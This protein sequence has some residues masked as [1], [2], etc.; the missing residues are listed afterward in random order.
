M[1]SQPGTSADQ[2][3]LNHIAMSQLFLNM[4]HPQHMMFRDQDCKNACELWY[5]VC[6]HY[7]SQESATLQSKVDRWHDVRKLRSETE[8]N[9]LTA[10]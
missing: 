5:A 6:D 2:L 7:D 3:K 9:T 8:T 1:A 10:F 4:E